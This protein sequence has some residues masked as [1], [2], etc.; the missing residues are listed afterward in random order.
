MTVLYEPVCTGQ[1]HAPVNAALLATAQAAYPH[2]QTIFMAE[3][4]HIT[5]VREHLV[6][7]SPG[8]VEWIPTEIAPR[9]CRDWRT[10][11]PIEW[12]VCGTALEAARRT[13]C[14]R[15]IACGTT[16]IGLVALKLRLQLQPRSPR[17]ALVFHTALSAFV[18]GRRGR[19]LLSYGNPRSLRF[20][21]LGDHI[22]SGL[23]RLLPKLDAR[24]RCLPHPYL[25]RDGP[26]PRSD[27]ADLTFGF[28]GLGSKAKGFPIFG[29]LAEDVV[30]SQHEP[31]GKVRFELV[32]RVAEEC[33]EYVTPGHRTYVSGT[34][35]AREQWPRALYDERAG[36]ITYAVFP[37]DRSEY[38]FIASGAILDAFAHGIPLIALRAEIFANYFRCM[39]DIGYLCEDYAELLYTVRSLIADFP[40]E[41]YELQR[42]AILDG[43]ALFEPKTLGH[44]LRQALDG[45]E[46]G[47][48]S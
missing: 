36:G 23:L 4:A 14:R 44:V 46:P 35:D 27:F 6:P 8:S 12:R 11:F 47:A 15:M 21:V 45:N 40:V 41:R 32:G 39:G 37:Y 3:A 13:A 31:A 1:E 10:R 48:D 9:R 5:A 7:A 28:L 34:F 38:Q 42:K 2:E 24:V 33:A 43:R 30:R 25:F 20:L 19:A 18:G 17:T 29:R 26:A 16:E 22:R